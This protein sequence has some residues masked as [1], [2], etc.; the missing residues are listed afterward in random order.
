[1]PI[2]R[3]SRKLSEILRT[4]H[5]RKYFFSL[6]FFFSSRQQ[7]SIH[8]VLVQIYRHNYFCPSHKY[9]NKH[10]YLYKSTE[11]TTSIFDTNTKNHMIRTSQ[12]YKGEHTTMLQ[13]SH[14]LRLYRVTYFCSKFTRRTY[15][16]SLSSK[17]YNC[18]FLFYNNEHPSRHKALCSA[19]IGLTGLT[20]REW[21]YSTKIC[22]L[23]LSL[24]N[25]QEHTSTPVS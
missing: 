1:M 9:N 10:T 15:C 6:L 17:L 14:T 21:T 24:L 19:L 8:P 23:F 7:K 13:L 2:C 12:I 3:A 5:K 18:A 11:A 20:E 4:V 16:T 22:A 25:K